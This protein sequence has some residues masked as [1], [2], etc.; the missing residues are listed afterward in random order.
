MRAYL[1][2]WFGVQFVNMTQLSWDGSR[3]AD[4]GYGRILIFSMDGGN[5]SSWLGPND[6]S[7]VVEG[8]FHNVQTWTPVTIRIRKAGSGL[9]IGTFSI[10]LYRGQ[11]PPI[12]EVRKQLATNGINLY[13]LSPQQGNNHIDIGFVPTSSWA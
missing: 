6:I 7:G 10:I 8:P 2:D 13:W 9:H 4:D 3:Y 1:S 12:I 11:V 5:E